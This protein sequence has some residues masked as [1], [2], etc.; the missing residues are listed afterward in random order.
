MNA[1]KRPICRREETGNIETGKSVHNP[2]E[3]SLSSPNGPR[4]HAKNGIAEIDRHTGQLKYL[5]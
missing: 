1:L 3:L 4:V 5:L 2:V